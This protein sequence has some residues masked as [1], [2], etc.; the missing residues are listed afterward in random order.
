M[1]PLLVRIARSQYRKTKNM[2]T[3]LLIVETIILSSCNG[4][5]LPTSVNDAVPN[6]YDINAPTFR[7]Q[8]EEL[9]EAI[10][11]CGEGVVSGVSGE[12]RCAYQIKLDA[13]FFVHPSQKT[14]LLQDP[15]WAYRDGVSFADAG[16]DELPDAYDL[17]DYMKNGQPEIRQQQ[18]GD[19]WAWAAHHGYEIV[20]AI[21][22]GK[23]VDDS[24]QTVLS[25]SNKGSCGGGYMSAVDFLK[26]GLPLESGFPYKNGVTGTCKYSRAELDAGWEPKTIGT[27]YIGG[28]LQFSR[29]LMTADG[30]RAKPTVK[31]MK[32]AM[33]KWKSP[34]VV[35]VAAYSMSGAGVYD[36]CSQIN[37]GGNHMVTI[38]GWEKWNGKDVAHV[39]NS[40]G[41]GHGDKGV[42][43]IVWECGDGKLNRGLGVSA[44]VVQY[45]PA[46]QPPVVSLGAAKQII[47][48]GS[49]V[50]LGSP[51][52]GQTCKWT[53][54]IGLSDP[55]SCQTY[56]S[57]ETST[58]YHLEARN[59]CG[60]SS[61]MKLVEVWGPHGRSPKAVTIN[62]LAEY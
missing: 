7:S 18:C 55:N 16:D 40:W 1:R 8:R 31:Q 49:S 23:V 44:K 54:S 22:D 25:C 51:A 14:G 48:H 59:D 35:T 37:S 60:T 9:T 62:G 20:Q 6:G 21:H 39:W 30:F 13:D 58:E 29:S 34:L 12:N 53:P 38:V 50:K 47:L 45:K 15:E 41:Q 10:G 4:S 19:C 5:G 26:G 61:A 56:A 2:K 27:P 24:V 28:S 36:S 42:S 17:R 32:A 46:C 57:P 43:R 11:S 33:Y 3:L 52:D